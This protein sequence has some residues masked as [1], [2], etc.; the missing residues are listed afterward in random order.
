M[1]DDF[2]FL[3]RNI[4]IGRTLSLPTAQKFCFKM[5]PVQGLN[6]SKAVISTMFL[7]KM[8]QLDVS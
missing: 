5:H 8:K 1:T 4:E 7:K 6:G 3:E 2:F